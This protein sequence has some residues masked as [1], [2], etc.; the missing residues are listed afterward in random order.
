D[1]ISG[2]WHWMALSVFQFHSA[3]YLGFQ[4]N[5]HGMAIRREFHT[6]SSQ[7]SGNYGHRRHVFALLVGKS[8]VVV[9]TWPMGR[10]VVQPSNGEKRRH[11]KRF[12][13]S[14][15]F[16]AGLFDYPRL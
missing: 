4:T 1:W 11:I 2:F 7:R 14:A 5:L 6:R 10:H 12:L 13:G 15:S 3:K 9:S 8:V 16:R